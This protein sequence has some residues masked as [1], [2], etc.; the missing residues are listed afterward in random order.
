MSQQS[1]TINLPSTHYYLQIVPTISMTVIN[2]RQYKIFGIA[3]GQRL[4]PMPLQPGQNADQRR[5]LFEARLSPGVNRIEVEVIA[6]PPRGAPKL[7][8]GQDVELER[9]TI[10]ANLLKS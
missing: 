9:I 1:I 7:T 8:P 10:F 2:N 6:G 5:P 4:N 3:N